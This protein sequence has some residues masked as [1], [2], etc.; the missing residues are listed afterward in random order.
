MFGSICKATEQK[1]KQAMAGSLCMS[2]AINTF[3]QLKCIKTHPCGLFIREEYHY[4]AATTDMMIKDTVTT[5][6]TVHYHKL[7][8]SGLKLNTNHD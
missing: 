8:P 2:V 6:N 5:H 4:L 3:E 7:S 1:N